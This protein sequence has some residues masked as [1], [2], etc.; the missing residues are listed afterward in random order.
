MPHVVMIVVLLLSSTLGLGAER[1]PVDLA[2]SQVELLRGA[3]VTGGVLRMT[4]KRGS[5]FNEFLHTTEKLTFVGG[6]DC[7]VSF[8]YTYSR[9]DGDGRAYAPGMARPGDALLLAPD[10]PAWTDLNTLMS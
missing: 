6:A 5:G 10:M 3:T 4:S 8:R 1:L 2:G 7:S 9:A